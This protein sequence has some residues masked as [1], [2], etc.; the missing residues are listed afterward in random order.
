MATL[1]D[2]PMLKA[3]MPFAPVFPHGPILV[4]IYLNMIIAVDNLFSSN[5]H[6]PTQLKLRFGLGM[7]GSAG[8]RSRF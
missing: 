8:L 2:V 3:P 6:D 1:E 4:A 5:P 7:F